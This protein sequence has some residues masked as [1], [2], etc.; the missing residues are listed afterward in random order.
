MILR[1]ER[2]TDEMDV[3]FSEIRKQSLSQINVGLFLSKILTLVRTYRVQIESNFATLVVGTVLLEGV[4]RQLD[5]ELNI[6]DVSVPYLF[7]SR[8]ATWREKLQI[9]WD[10][11]RTRY[12]EPSTK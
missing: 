8:K 1:L 12:L 11:F 6:L 4:G 9:A 5:P 7:L 3:L 10:R 2:F